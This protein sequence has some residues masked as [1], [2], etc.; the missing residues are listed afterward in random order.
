MKF[1]A[2]ILAA[3]LFAGLAHAQTVAWKTPVMAEMDE[4]GTVSPL[5][6][7][8]RS[9]L[10]G[11]QQ[12]ATMFSQAGTPGLV[13]AGSGGERDW[14]PFWFYTPYV[15]KVATNDGRILWRWQP[16]PGSLPEGEI[17]RS[18]IDPAGHVVVAGWHAGEGYDLLLAK[19]DGATGLPLWRAAATPVRAVDVALDRNGNVFT[20]GNGMGEREQ[21]VMKYNGAT[22]AIEWSRTI[23]DANDSF[24]DF[25]VAVDAAGDAVAASPYGGPPSQMG[26]QIAKF[27]GADGQ[28]LWS[29]RFPCSICGWTGSLDALRISGTGDILLCANGSLYDLEGTSGVTRWEYPVDDFNLF[30]LVEGAQGGL[31]M[32]GRRY[33]ED[34]RSAAEVRRISQYDGADI[35]RVLYSAEAREG[36][37]PKLQGRSDGKLLLTWAT[38]TR[39]VDSP[40]ATHAGQLDPDDG[41]LL[42]HARFGA[43]G[44][45]L[46]DRPVSIE[47]TPDGS[48]FVGT[49][50]DDVHV[51]DGRTW[52]VYKLTGPFADDVFANGFER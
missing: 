25:L 31:F 41:H 3:G 39:D 35:W 29:R 20:T 1:L 42:W 9:A 52:M 37:A 38:F 4:G 22:G 34:Y 17:W 44:P 46:P 47:Q 11:S 12:P 51:L 43:D 7:W 48:V 50:S 23:P 33:L 6:F 40:W 36:Y 14:G 27:S 10:R 26:V 19:L 30:D 2:W 5:A 24:D 32:A 16:E 13:L 49:F 45:S 8:P 28:T 18:A 21:R 15:A